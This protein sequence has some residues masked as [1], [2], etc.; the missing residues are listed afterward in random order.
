MAVPTG[1]ILLPF[2]RV[3]IFYSGEIHDDPIQPSHIEESIHRSFTPYA[4]STERHGTLPNSGL[5][6]I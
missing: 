5:P 2:K 3:A 1:A 4:V 6:R